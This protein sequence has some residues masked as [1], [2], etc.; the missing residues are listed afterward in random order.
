MSG[1][2]VLLFPLLDG[3]ASSVVPQ[4]HPHLAIVFV[5]ARVLS[6]KDVTF[7]KVFASVI[8]NVLIK[9]LIRYSGVASFVHYDRLPTLVNIVV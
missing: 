3:L 7:L 5:K 1:P 8:L 4:T 6:L 2:L 9:F